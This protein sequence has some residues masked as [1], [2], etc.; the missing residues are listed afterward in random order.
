MVGWK[1]AVSKNRILW[2]RDGCHI[3]M[4]R[5]VN[6]WLS[7]SVFLIVTSWGSGVQGVTTVTSP[8]GEENA[9]SMS[10]GQG[11]VLGVVEGLTEYLPVSSTG[12][13]LVMQK[14]LGMGNS[15]SNSP[16]ERESVKAAA[17]A[18]AICIQAGAILAVLGLYGRR[19]KQMLRGVMGRD[20]AGLK[21]ATNMAAGFLPAAVIGLLLEAR[22]KEHLFG[23]WPVVWA[24]FV[25]GIGILAL[26]WWKGRHPERPRNTKAL[27]ELTWKM[28]LV[29]GLAQCI[30]MW[31]GVSRSLVTIVGGVMV[32]LTLL[33]A[34]EFSFLLGVVTLTAAASYDGIRFGS[35]ML[36]NFDA[37]PLVVGLVFAFLSAVVAVKCMVNYLSRHGL[38]V[39]GYYRVALAFLVAVCYAA[40]L[41]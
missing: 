33:A 34:V 16:R 5:H 36:E 23:V 3:L 30:A 25:G 7:W 17:D 27:E 39:F 15:N 12:H 8:P 28:A 4:H 11:A 19:F 38:G 40:N 20:P 1:S 41:I 37:Q 29:I 24:W 32:G 14:V 35:I 6:R 21:M 31:P 2:K 22:I 9:Y 18:Y 10:V 26:D 13:L